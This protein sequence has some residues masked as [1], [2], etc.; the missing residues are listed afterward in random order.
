MRLVGLM[1]FFSFGVGCEEE[2]KCTETSSLISIQEKPDFTYEGFFDKEGYPEGEVKIEVWDCVDVSWWG[3]VEEQKIIQIYS[4]SNDCFED[5]EQ[6]IFECDD[7]N[8]PDKF[9]RDE[10]DD[11]VI[12]IEDCDDADPTIGNCNDESEE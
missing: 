8:A 6:F 2:T 7:Q 1:V 11:G 4:N 9:I 12:R 3:P 5:V 10:D